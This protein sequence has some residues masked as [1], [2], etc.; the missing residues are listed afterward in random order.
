MYDHSNEDE[1]DDTYYYYDR[2]EPEQNVEG[3]ALLPDILLED[4]FGYLPMKNRAR[5]A[6]VCQNWNRIFVSEA[7]WDTFVY[8]DYTFTRR[9]FTLH[10]GYQ[11]AID[12]WKL[13][14]LINKAT[15][16]WRH[17]VVKPVTILHNLYEFIRTITNFTEYYEN[18]ANEQPLGNIRSFDFEWELVV[19]KVHK[20]PQ[21]D[22]YG[23]GGRLLESVSGLLSHLKAFL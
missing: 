17:L 5:S 18:L 22:V 12:H 6:Q 21:P 15:R 23:T 11:H 3:W 2:R 14:L 20:D 9:R 8:K 10:A 16:L 19:Q 13:R 1:E 4:I 7:C